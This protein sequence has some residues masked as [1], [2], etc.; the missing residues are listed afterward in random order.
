MI[1]DV[2]GW[3]AEDKGKRRQN[4]ASLLLSKIGRSGHCTSPVDGGA[5]SLSLTL[6]GESH[7][8]LRERYPRCSMIIQ[9]LEM[10]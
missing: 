10:I 2:A 5:H 6:D 9:I 8:E 1:T 7:A 4:V 3:E